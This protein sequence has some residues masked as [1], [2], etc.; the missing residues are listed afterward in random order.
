MW[1]L[2]KAEC[3]AIPHEM[4]EGTSGLAELGSPLEPALGNDANA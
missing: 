3:E 1:H 4:D 2:H